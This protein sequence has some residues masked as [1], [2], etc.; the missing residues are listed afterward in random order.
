MAVARDLHLNRESNYLALKT[1]FAERNDHLR[2]VCKKYF[3]KKKKN[4]EEEEEDQEVPGAKWLLYM[5]NPDFMF[6]LIPKVASSALS[7]FILS[8]HQKAAAAGQ[9]QRAADK[10]G[11]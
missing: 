8:N 7:G 5:R 11:E 2:R 6:C 3:K 10:L 4:E 9:R 1:L